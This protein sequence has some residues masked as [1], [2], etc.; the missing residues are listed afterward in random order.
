LIKSQKILKTSPARR[1]IEETNPCKSCQ[2]QHRLPQQLV[3]T[4]IVINLRLDVATSG[5][6]TVTLTD[7]NST[8]QQ[9]ATAAIQKAVEETA[10]AKAYLR[11]K[12]CS[13]SH[14]SYQVQQSPQV[15]V[16]LF[17]H[18]TENIPRTV[19]MFRNKFFGPYGFVTAYSVGDSAAEVTL[20]RNDLRVVL[21]IEGTPEVLNSVKKCFAI[22]FDLELQGVLDYSEKLTLK[23]CYVIEDLELPERTMDMEK[24]K[25]LFPYLRGVSFESYFNEQP[26]MLIGSPHAYAI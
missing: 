2:L 16:V 1:K 25:V 7:A 26:V 3:L 4:R 14:R 20:V 23:N 17:N 13:K 6:A 15:G 10:N 18:V 19:K 5:L 11:A 8:Q 9:Q 22:K 12:S 21:G 24:I